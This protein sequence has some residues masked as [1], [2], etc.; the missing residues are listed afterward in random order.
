MFAPQPPETNLP[1]FRIFRGAAPEFVS[2][3]Q[4]CMADPKRPEDVIEFEGDDPYDGCRYLIKRVHRY[5]K[6]SAD[7]F[8]ARNA[9][10]KVLASAPSTFDM[11]RSME[12]YE[13]DTK[14]NEDF[15]V[16]RV[17]APSQMRRIESK[18]RL[19]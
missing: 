2:A 9:V 15:S 4:A 17:Y 13:S 5:F 3:I 14:A 12:R 16:R 8:S 7:E 18:L 6:E 1:K 19:H 10:A 11:Y